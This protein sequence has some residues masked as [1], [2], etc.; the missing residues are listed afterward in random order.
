MALDRDVL[1]DH[2]SR[3]GPF[4]FQATQADP[5]P[6][7]VAGGLRPGSEL[8]ISTKDGFFKTREGHVYLGSL[9]ILALVEVAGTRAY[10]QIDL[11]KLDPALIDPDQDQVQGS[12]DRKGGGWVAK[13]P[14]VTSREGDPEAVG[15]ALAD[16]AEA[17][18]G[19]DAPEVTAKSLESGRVSYC[20][21]IPPEA[22]QV[23]T[24][25]SEGPELFHQGVVQALNDP[26]VN[27]TPPPPLGFYKTEV[28]RALALA[29][30]LIASAAESVGEPAGRLLPDWPH[31][32]HAIYTRDLLIGA[33]RDRAR[34]GQL[35]PADSLRAAQHV[36]EV[37]PDVQPELGWPMTRDACVNIAK[38]GAGVITSLRDRAST[39]VAAAAAQAAMI[40]VAEVPDQS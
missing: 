34:A 10:L 36:A 12:F 39:A 29:R 30:S 6:A 21:I 40:A 13:P 23:V 22:I 11:S 2:I 20:G 8:G 14:P 37:V 19:F 1:D 38:A 18:E 9:T 26:R 32:E 24:F 27:L 35:V 17:T 16:W 15:Q 31:S 3:R 7:L 28:A 4:M 5:V 25:R 33:A